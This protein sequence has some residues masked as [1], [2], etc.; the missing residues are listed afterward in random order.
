MLLYTMSQ[1]LDGKDIDD[2]VSNPPHPMIHNKELADRIQKY[3]TSPLNV[4]EHLWEA[5]ISTGPMGSSGAIR[6]EL[7]TQLAETRDRETVALFRVHHALCDGVS[8][9]VAVGDLC[10]EASDLDAAVAKLAKERKEKAMH[11]TLL[12]RIMHVFQLIGFYIIGSAYALSLQ[13]WRTLVSVN[14][15][16]TSHGSSWR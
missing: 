4:R 16:D 1:V 14:P 6:K 11:K 8:L 13:A 5:E 15:F 10:D 3:L 2:Y 12:Q 7:A 9:S